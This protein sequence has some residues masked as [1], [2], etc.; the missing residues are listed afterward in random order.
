MGKHPNQY[1]HNVANTVMGQIGGVSYDYSRGYGSQ[2]DEANYPNLLWQWCGDKVMKVL[3]KMGPAARGRIIACGVD[4]STDGSLAYHE[5]NDGLIDPHVTGDELLT[6][7][8]SYVVVAA[9]VDIIRASVRSLRDEEERDRFE[10]GREKHLRE[11]VPS[12]FVEWCTR[13]PL[14]ES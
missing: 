5:V 11:G 12:E 14:L 10:Y 1:I 6:L 4:H 7:L 8:S 9:I 13:N 2:V 3:E